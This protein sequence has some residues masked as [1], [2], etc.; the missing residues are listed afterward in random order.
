MC[1]GGTKERNELLKNWEP[2]VRINLDL[3]KY[4]FLFRFISNN[5]VANA[6][7]VLTLIG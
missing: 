2:R 5:S 4:K 3:K 7:R 6:I 1:I